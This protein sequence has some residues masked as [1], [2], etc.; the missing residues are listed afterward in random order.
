M[1]E[2][3]FESM[4]DEYVPIAMVGLTLEGS[5]LDP[6]S[7]RTAMPEAVRPFLAHGG[8]ETVIAQFAYTVREFSK[9]PEDLGPIDPSHH[10]EE[11]KGGHAI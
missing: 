10:R 4:G 5:I 3:L 7:I 2:A 9:H 8:A 11:N 1:A 6:D